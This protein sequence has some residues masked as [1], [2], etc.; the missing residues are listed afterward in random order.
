MEAADQAV[1]AGQARI[2]ANP[3]TPICGFAAISGFQLEV[4]ATI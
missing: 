3:T 4:S 2:R 1:P